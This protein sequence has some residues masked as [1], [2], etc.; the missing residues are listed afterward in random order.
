MSNKKNLL[1]ESQIRQ[2]MKLAKLEPLASGFVE[3]LTESNTTEEDL[4][5][6]HGRGR[7]EG[8]AG[9][10][11][12]VD[13]GRAGA[14]LR[15]LDEPELDVDVAGPE[16]EEAVDLP[17][18][19][20]E[21]EEVMEPGAEGVPSEEEV[22]AAIKVIARA[23]GVE[24][25]DIEATSTGE[26]SELE[27]EVG[28]EP[29][30]LPSEEGPEEPGL[31]ELEEG[32]DELEE[33]AREDEWKRIAG[34]GKIGGSLKPD[35]KKG[36]Q[37]YTPTP[38]EIAAARAAPRSGGTTAQRLGIDPYKKSEKPKRAAGSRGYGFEEGLTANTD[39]LVEQITKRVAARILKSALSSKK[40]LN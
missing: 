15:E 2:F 22:L 6:S 24:G 11:A 38:A 20:P 29:E 23:A 27:P 26:P 39:D 33:G 5:E 8:P 13:A 21:A 36:E 9:Y 4:E 10:G 30:P 17:V 35:P 7:G 14:R 12:P 18:V 34:G 31:E 25:I 32:D 19:D 3:G 16:G 40:K 37:D 28:L 1:N